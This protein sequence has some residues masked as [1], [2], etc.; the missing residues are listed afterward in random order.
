MNYHYLN[1]LEIV[2][3]HIEEGT[4]SKTYQCDLCGNKKYINK[5]KYDIHME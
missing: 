2:H 5:K 4:K 3:N 1:H